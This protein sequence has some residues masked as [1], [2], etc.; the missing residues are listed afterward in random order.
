MGDADIWADTE[1]D[2]DKFFSDAKFLATNLTDG[3]TFSDVLPL[4]N[5]WAGFSP[6]KEV[7]S[8]PFVCMKQLVRSDMATRVVSELEASPKSKI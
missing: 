1:A 8:T 5:W 7:G 6:S 2:K 4:V 3:Q